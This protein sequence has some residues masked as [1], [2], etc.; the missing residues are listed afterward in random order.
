MGHHGLRGGARAIALALAVIGATSHAEAQPAAKVYRVGGL[1]DGAAAAPRTRPLLEAF[2]QGLRDLGWVEGRNLALDIRFTEGSPDRLAPLAAELVARNP[3]VLVGGGTG[4]TL[5]LVHATSTIPIVTFSSDAVASGLVA[6]LAHPG[7][8]VTGLSNLSPELGGKRL[9]ILKEIVPTLTRVAL[10]GNSANPPTRQL[11]KE[12]EQAARTL[13][14]ATIAVDVRGPKDFDTASAAISQS[15]AEGML[16]SFD[17]ATFV[18]LQRIVDFARERRLPAVYGIR[19]FAD[20]G[21]LLSY[22]VSL[23]DLFRRAATYVDRILRGA[24][25]AALPVEQPTKFE[26]IV[27]LRAA[28]ALGLAV[29]SSVLARADEVIE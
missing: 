7:G 22:G 12:T 23:A 17:P 9:Q 16:V 18:Q 25:P 11:V 5:A 13:G 20:A 26:L 21:G 10:V 19:E 3:D 27:N 8:N 6:N 24:S 4:P 1:V 28:K 2:L 29:P 15:R 14:V